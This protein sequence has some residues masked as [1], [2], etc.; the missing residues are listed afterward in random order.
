MVDRYAFMV[1]RCVP[2]PEDY[3]NQ[4]AYVKYADYAA[5][6]QRFKKLEAERD[7]LKEKFE[8]LEAD[9]QAENDNLSLKA[10]NKL[11]QHLQLECDRIVQAYRIEFE[12]EKELRAENERLKQKFPP[13]CNKSTNSPCEWSGTPHSQDTCIKCGTKFPTWG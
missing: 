10:F 5:L 9:I 8:F 4:S 1:A 12:S 2:D 3:E 13:E 7:L 6:E 11:K